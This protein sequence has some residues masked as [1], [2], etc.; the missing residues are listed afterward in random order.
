MEEYNEDFA[1]Q[2]GRYVARMGFTQQELANKIGMHRNTIVKWMTRASWPTR[3]GQVLR[4]ADELSLTK[5]ERKALLQAARFPLDQW[6]TE[7]W[8]IPQQR[9]MFFTGRDE[10]FQSL[11]TLLIPGST[12]AL[13]QAISGLGGIGKTHTAIEYAYR[14]HQDHEA[15]LWL[16]ADSWET[17]VSACVQLAEE[18]EL[19]EQKESDQVIA[20]VQHWLRK[21][22]FWL[23]ILDNVENPQEI[24]TRFLPTQHQ[25]SVLITTRVHDVEPLAQTQVLSTM[26]EDEGILF[27][28]RR[29]RK[30]APNA[31]LDQAN[32]TQ[33]DEARQIWQLMQGLPLALDQAGAYIR[34]TDC[35]FS[36]YQAQ[37][38]RRR[39]EL[40]ARRGKRFIGHE[41]SVATTFSLAFE[42]IETLNPVA[43]DMLRACAMLANETIPEEIFRKGA[44]HLGPLLTSGEADRDQ[45]IGVLQDYSLVQRNAE[46]ETLTIH[47][48][49]QAVL[50][51]AMDESTGQLWANRVVYAV[52]AALPEMGEQRARRT[53]ERLLAHAQNCARLIGQYHLTSVEGSQLLYRTGAF[54]AEQQGRYEEAEGLYVQCLLLREQVLG[55]EHPMTAYP[56]YALAELYRKQGK[57]SAA[58]PLYQRTIKIWN[59]SLGPEH[60]DLVLPLKGLAELS[61][62]QGKY[63]DAELLYQQALRVGEEALELEHPHLDALLNC[64]ANLYREQGRYSE[65][66]AIYQRTLRIDDQTLSPEHPAE[67]LE[68][69]HLAD[70]YQDQGRYDEAES[71]YLRILHTLEQAL[72]PEHPAIAPLLHNLA[73][74]YLVQGKHAEAEPLFRRSLHIH[75]QVFGPDHHQL[76]HS[77]NSLAN[78]SLIQG[79]YSEAEVLYQRAVHIYEQAVDPTS[80]HIASPLNNLGKIAQEQ[81]KFEEAESLY[82]RALQIRERALGPE[83][84]EVATSLVT[85]AGFYGSQKR[86][87]EAE[88][89]Y[90]RALRIREQV[91]G[92]NHPDLAALLYDLANLCCEQ[93]KYGEAEPLQ[94]SAL[95]IWKQGQGASHSHL[96]A[97]FQSIAKRSSEQAKYAEA[98]SFYQQALHILEQATEPEQQ[99][100]A[101][102]SNSLAHLYKIQGKYAEAEPLYQRAV[103]IQEQI[104]G[105]DHPDVANQLD[106]LAGLYAAQGKY[107]EAEPLCQRALRIQEQALG[108]EHQDVAATLNNLAELYREQEKYEEAEPLYLR[109]IHIW[110]SS[111]KPVLLHLAQGLNNLALIYS[112]QKKYEEAERLYQ[113]ALHIREQELGEMHPEVATSRF[114]L[115]VLYSV[116][117]RYIEAESLL[118]RALEIIER[119]LGLDHP[120]TKSFHRFYAVI[121]RAMGREYEAN[122]E[123]TFGQEKELAQN[124]KQRKTQPLSLQQ[125]HDIQYNHVHKRLSDLVERAP[126]HLKGMGSTVLHAWEEAVSEESKTGE[127]FALYGLPPKTE[128]QLVTESRIHEGRNPRPWTGE[129]SRQGKGNFYLIDV[130]QNPFEIALDDD[131]YSAPLPIN[132]ALR[133]A[134]DV[135]HQR[136]FRK[137][138]GMKQPDNL[139]CRRIY[140]GIAST[141]YALQTRGEI[142]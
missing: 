22:R 84:R 33:R 95:S 124:Q 111:E 116:Q 92:P 129:G 83:H 85:L 41:E 109:A 91:L 7:V 8:T 86:Y 56:L 5:Q 71:L 140:R 58:T 27:L 29:T 36:Q 32:T 62:M 61:H 132:V 53:F 76:A 108:P 125:E 19:P 45:A 72:D 121:L 117:G 73:N 97:L 6:P 64:L 31:G 102:L 17:L 110:E 93:G 81:G 127:A 130:D 128:Y 70:L 137:D 3:R 74:L 24:L 63:E 44:H 77:L 12:T 35:S 16:Q 126:E 96:A 94:Q 113:R 105:A 14:F 104:S 87:S 34:E 118:I 40:L 10:V 65:A 112:I 42:R 9:D 101:R 136:F 75:E 133:Q 114:N 49:V 88:A 123:E 60:P 68:L 48:L 82:Q 54:L 107:E 15:V 43:A 99:Q 38:E 139:E 4:L 79:K 18:L 119:T 57:Y 135:T 67:A 66:E 28:L 2:L 122:Q 13:T 98:E 23:L 100:I 50:K 142:E 80:A 52:E 138:G 131:F 26:S 106:G 89:C 69:Q 20:E 120:K 134:F 47:R 103:R 37:Y 141:T 55:S 21:H 115:A 46:A 1:D 90:W 39:A 25:G 78:L 30:V 11:R 51:D 59:H